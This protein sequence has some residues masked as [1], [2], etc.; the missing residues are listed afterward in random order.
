MHVC[1]IAGNIECYPDIHMETWDVWECRLAVDDKNLY[2]FQPV[3]NNAKTQL[4]QSCSSGQIS[5]QETQY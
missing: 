3:P 5:M 4:L 1:F 2:S